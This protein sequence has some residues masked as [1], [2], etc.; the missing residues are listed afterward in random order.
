LE[1]VGV[2][3]PT[4]EDKENDE[5]QAPFKP[6]RDVAVTPG[7][8]VFRN[9]LI[10][11]I[12]YSPQTPKVYAEPIFIV[13]SWIMKYYILDLSPHNSMVRFLVEQGHTVFM[14]SWRNPGREDRDLGMDDYLDSGLFAALK[15]V[16]SICKNRCT[17]SVTV[18]VAPCSRS[19]LP[20][21][22]GKNSWRKAIR[23][24]GQQHYFARGTD[25]FQRTR[26]TRIIYR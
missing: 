9:H 26:R 22:P 1:D 19:V 25:R 24:H 3:L 13:P 17:R 18:S 15:E 2:S 6:G 14:I 10:E 16:H 21:W 12:Q 23:Q 4:N 7:K 8:V 5:E 20:R 11:L